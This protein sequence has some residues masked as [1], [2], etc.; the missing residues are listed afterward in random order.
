MDLEQSELLTHMEYPKVCASRK[1]VRFRGD[2][3]AED[4]RAVQQA[5]MAKEDDDYQPA[6]LVRRKRRRRSGTALLETGDDK[7]SVVIV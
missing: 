4:D 2:S 3:D 7:V 6:A 5:W 1:R